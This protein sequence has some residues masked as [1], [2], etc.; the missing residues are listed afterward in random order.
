MDCATIWFYFNPVG[1]YFPECFLS[2]QVN[3]FPEKIPVKLLVLLLMK[4]INQSE[5]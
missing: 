3:V 2:A 1:H 4:G 5:Q